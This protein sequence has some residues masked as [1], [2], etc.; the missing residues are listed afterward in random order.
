MY[1]ARVVYSVVYLLIECRTRFQPRNTNSDP[2]CVQVGGKENNSAVFPRGS[3][4]SVQ[5][6]RTEVV[7]ANK[8][9]EFLPLWKFRE[10]LPAW[11]S[12]TR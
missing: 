12:G 5:D 6:Y 1:W 4:V 11:S 3:R 2:V 8:K 7:A 10:L 9:L